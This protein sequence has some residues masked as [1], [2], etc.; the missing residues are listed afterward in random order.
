MLA[1]VRNFV[2]AFLIAAAVFG[3]I[4]WFITG[5]IAENVIGIEESPE[6]TGPSGNLPVQ[7]PGVLPPGNTDS[8]GTT[9][10]DLNGESFTV[11]LIGTDYRADDF[12]D[13]IEDFSGSTYPK[14][15]T[16]LLTKKVRTQDADLM[17]LV[18][19]Y[20]QTRQMIFTLIPANTRVLVNGSYYLLNTRYDKGGVGEIVDFVSYLTAVPIDYYIKANVTDAGSI[21]D[22]ID[23]VDVDVPSNIINPYYN[24][25]RTKENAKY[26]GITG[27]RDFETITMIEAGMRHIDSSNMFALLH[28]RTSNFVQGER[29]GV[30][31]D[32]AKQTLSKAVSTEY[33][34]RAADLFGRVSKYT[35]TNM[36]VEDLMK[37]LDFFTHYGEFEII[38]LSYPGTYSTLDDR[39][40]F[41]PDLTEAYSMFRSYRGAGQ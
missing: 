26:S 33:L 1:A 40:C 10:P 35:E 6:D 24:S 27:D 18:T 11:L 20:E 12:N 13:Y 34:G 22:I 32:L 38:T 30:L 28:Y 16:G 2:I 9:Y 29:E 37:N 25:R 3:S 21:I 41:I 14:Y 7:T 8:P 19:V 39:D 4:A 5:F 31:I 15:T 23:G 36:K 17:I